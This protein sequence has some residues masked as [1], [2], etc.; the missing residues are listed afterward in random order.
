MNAAGS[1][2]ATDEGSGTESGWGN[3]GE[4]GGETEWV[5][6]EAYC[7]RKCVETTDAETEEVKREAIGGEIGE[8][9]RW[10]RD[11][12]RTGWGSSSMSHL[13]ILNWMRGAEELD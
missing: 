1:G 8:G 9:S 13:A 2:P 12:G 5:M 3:D 11:G 4:T 6:N 7:G 10:E